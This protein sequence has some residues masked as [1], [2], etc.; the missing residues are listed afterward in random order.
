MLYDHS[1]LYLANK[2]A[3]GE[4]F[5]FKMQ[6]GEFLLLANGA[7]L[8]RIVVANY[9]ENGAF[10]GVDHVENGYASFFDGYKLTL[11]E[12]QKAFLWNRSMYGNGSFTPL[13]E[14]VE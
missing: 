12:N 14:I 6:E 2:N 11:E 8:I 5:T 4:V 9:D 1:N 10:L 13:G 7:S 3:D